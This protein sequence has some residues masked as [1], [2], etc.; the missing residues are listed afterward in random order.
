MKAIRN[1]NPALRGSLGGYARPCI[2]GEIK[3]HFRDKYW[4]VHVKRSAQELMLETREAARQLTQD[5]GRTSAE[6]DLPATSG[7]AARTCG[8][9]GGRRSRGGH[10]RWTRRWPARPPP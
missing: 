10:R 3:R 6:P 2:T 9:P 4:P 5:L 8:M 1:F 7:S